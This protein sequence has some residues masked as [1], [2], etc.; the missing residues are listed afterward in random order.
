MNAIGIDIGGTK[1][2]IAAVDSSG[3]LTA[4]HSFDTLPEN[5]FASALQRIGSAIVMIV[6]DSDLSFSE[7]SRIGIGCT[8][9]IDPVQGTIHNPHTLPTWDGCNL[10]GPLHDRFGIPVRMENDADVAALGEYRFGAGRGS[11]SMVMLTFG[12]GI[13]FSAII[14]G[15]IYRGVDG[16]H[17]EMGHSPTSVAGPMC[18]CG[19]TG[20]FESLASGTAIER[21]GRSQGY[22][23]ARAVFAGS[24]AGDDAAQAI[25]GDAMAAT[26]SAAWTVAHTFLPDRIVLGGGI[27]DEHHDLFVNAITLALSRAVMVPQ[28]K[29]S[30]ARAELRNMAGVIGAASL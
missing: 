8:G 1:I 21:R 9:P 26:A 27:I 3:K 22:S 20:C 25:I 18:Y 28:E 29:I 4:H 30:V 13:G 11:K 16:A 6:E 2:A 24:I 12:T 19:I 14:D 7:I 17:P 15:E 5:G 10:V 23:D